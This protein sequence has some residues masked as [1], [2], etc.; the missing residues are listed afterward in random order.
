MTAD[1][2]VIPYLA[3][4]LGG[5]ENDIAL[6]ISRR[7]IL[8]DNIPV[9]ILE[10]KILRPPD[11]SITKGE[12]GCGKLLIITNMH[13][14]K[15]LLASPYIRFS[16]DSLNCNPFRYCRYDR[17]NIYSSVF[18]ILLKCHR[19]RKAACYSYVVTLVQLIGFVL[20]NFLD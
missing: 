14:S 2:P 13:I 19:T 1:S 10:V 9:P 7:L 3:F 4:C 18:F 20:W 12:A 11:S 15:V 5:C 17:F 8:A 16:L 6:D